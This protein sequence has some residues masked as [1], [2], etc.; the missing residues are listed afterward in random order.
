MEYLIFILWVQNVIG[1]FYDICG[2]ILFNSWMKEE[3]LFEIRN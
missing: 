2:A 1:D 3:T